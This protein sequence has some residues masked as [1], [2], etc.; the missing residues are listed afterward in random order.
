MPTELPL[1]VRSLIAFCGVS[2]CHAQTKKPL[3]QRN[4]VVS[5]NMRV[6]LQDTLFGTGNGVSTPFFGIDMDH[7]DAIVTLAYAQQFTH[8]RL[9]NYDSSQ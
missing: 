2:C 8:G 5:G 7:A 6:A 1:C 3:L 4:P 9:C